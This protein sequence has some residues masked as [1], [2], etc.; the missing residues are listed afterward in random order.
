MD[1]KFHVRIQAIH[2]PTIDY[3]KW[4]LLDSLLIVRPL[5]KICNLTT[6][7]ETIFSDL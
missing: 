7:F 3:E 1:I 4:I 5:I 6:G 2:N